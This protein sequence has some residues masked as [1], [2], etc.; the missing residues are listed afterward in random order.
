M[1]GQLF[2]NILSLMILFFKKMW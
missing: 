2:R 1:C